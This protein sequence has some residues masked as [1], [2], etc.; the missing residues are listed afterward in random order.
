ME[1]NRR[2]SKC[3]LMMSS[4]MTPTTDGVL[5]AVEANLAAASVTI[6]AS[7][8][9]ISSA[10]GSSAPV[11]VEGVPHNLAVMPTQKGPAGI[12]F[13][14]NDGCRVVLP[15]TEHPWRV[16][17]SDI[18]TG[19]IF[20]EAELKGGGI[21]SIKKYYIRFRLEIWQHGKSI[22]VH[23]YSAGDRDVLV[24]FPVDTLGDPLAWFAYALKF[25]R[26]H[27]CRLT[28]SMSST[29]IGL[30]REFLLRNQFRHRAGSRSAALLCELYDRPLFSTQ[31]DP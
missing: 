5:T 18:D 17:L 9:A 21:K 3:G 25:K 2:F 6:G 11:S 22:F 14:F 7:A 24:R 23:E 1:E 15:E 31:P 19:N 28:C 20:F 12:L 26:Q 8:V 16:R 10:S 13:D 27:G 30:L 29:I 4:A